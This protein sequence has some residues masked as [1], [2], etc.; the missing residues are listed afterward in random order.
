MPAI[1]P[2]ELADKWLQPLSDERDLIEIQH[3]LAPY[4]DEDLKAHTV[5]RLRGKQ[6]SGNHPGISSEVTYAELA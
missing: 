5:G 1:L 6:Y 2:P 3:L 4:P